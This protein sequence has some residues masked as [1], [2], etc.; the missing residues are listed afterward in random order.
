[1]L[2][3]VAANILVLLTRHVKLHHSFLL[4]APLHLAVITKQPKLVEMLMKTG[5]DPS[6]LDHEGRTALHLAAHTGD[7]A[8][9]RLILGMLGERHAH[10][11]NSADFSGERYT[12]HCLTIFTQMALKVASGILQH[13]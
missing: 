2:L 10:L 1:M 12:C 3:A 13:M 5:A 9:L 11:I 7:E 6:L 8:T 4:Q